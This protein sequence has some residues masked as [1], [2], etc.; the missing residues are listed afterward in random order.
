MDGSKGVSLLELVMA[1][2]L[3]AILLGIGAPAFGDLR[4]DAQ[5]TAAVND[6]VGSIHLARSEAIK[7]GGVVSLCPGSPATGCATG[8]ADWSVGWLV[9]LNEDRDRP[10]ALDPDDE[11]LRF[12]S[13]AARITIRSNRNGYSFRPVGQLDVNGSIVICDARG[14]RAARVVIISHSGRP[15]VSQRDAS[16]RPL[17]CPQDSP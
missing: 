12:R 2:A 17:E 4:M 8:A 6:L 15:R 1:V 13:P 5:R 7:R 9:F 10:P 11:I 16:G 3:L 14:S